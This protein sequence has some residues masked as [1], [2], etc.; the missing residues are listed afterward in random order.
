[1]IKSEF[2]DYVVDLLSPYGSIK[3]RAMFGG[4]G[5]YKN[6]VIVAIIA[7]DELYFKTNNK[8]F[9]DYAERGS[10]PFTY[11]AHGKTVKMSYWQV[12][13]DI[14]EDPILLGEWLGLAFEISLASKKK[15]AQ[16]P[17]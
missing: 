4:Y 6:N 16:L 13:P 3:P 1:M 17:H 10:R 15:K 7:D 5:I 2:I 11:E 14:M 12:P 9:Q 8:S